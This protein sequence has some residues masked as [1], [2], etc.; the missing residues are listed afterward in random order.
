MANDDV[1]V[2]GG[3]VRLGRDPAN[4][5]L[6]VGNTNGGF[7]LTPSSTVAPG[8][9]T[10]L[11]GISNTQG[12]ILYRGASSWAALA[13]GA[14]GYLLS[15]NGAAANPS[16]IAPYSYTPPWT[17]VVKTSA[18][19]SVTNSTTLA[20]ATGL[21]FA[22]TS[23]TYYSFI[24]GMILESVTS[25]GVKIAITTP[26]S[27]LLWAPANSNA[28]PGTNAS[29]TA[30]NVIPTASA[31]GTYSVNLMGYFNCSSNG[32]L[33]LQFAQISAALATSATIYKG[34]WLRYRTV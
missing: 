33:Q 18:D 21:S 7:T 5:E 15:A 26:S 9:Q 13:P 1:T 30:I 22:V 3:Q 24:F 6:L 25:R 11:D 34:S 14:S 32:T 4:N 23:G 29:G 17:D 2:W 8:I 19:Q 10:L 27:G 31:S 16:W 20:D 28:V 12:S